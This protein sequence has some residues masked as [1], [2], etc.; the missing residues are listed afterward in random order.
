MILGL[1]APHTWAASVLPVLL[2]SVLG[3]VKRG[4]LDPLL[5]C[6]LLLASVLMQSAVNT[7]N[8][9][10]DYIRHTDTRD[11]CSDP[12]DA[13]LVYNEIA[14][15]KA[16]LLGLAFLA[17]A[18]CLGIYVTCRCGLVPLAIGV[19]GGVIIL[20]Y[21]FGKKPISHLPLGETISGIV[22]GGLITEAAFVSVS[23]VFE[24]WALLMSVPLI[25]G[26]GMIML[27]NNLCDIEKDMTAGR[28]T[29]PVLLGR[30]RVLRLY[31][32]VLLVWPMLTILLSLS[33]SGGA[34]LLIPTIV[35]TAPQIKRQCSLMLTPQ[36]RTQAMQGIL[37][38]NML[39]GM[40]YC[41]VLLAGRVF[42]PR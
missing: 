3:I 26:I 1:A 14:P 18:G 17:A 24:W 36:V 37:W 2:G 21:A 35:M 13:I 34:V 16:L 27:T 31:R 20:L 40:G 15:R 28:Q 30:R 12:F 9:Y 11:N 6:C 5:F 32:A 19:I 4:T 33:F 42:C 23:G 41:L 29:L 22:M 25:I 38:L 10:S 7:L 39:I 8:D